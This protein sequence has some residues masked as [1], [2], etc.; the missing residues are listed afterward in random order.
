VRK[1]AACLFGVAAIGAQLT[2]WQMRLQEARS[3]PADAATTLSLLA[4]DE[5]NLTQSGWAG[6]EQLYL[7]LAAVHQSLQGPQQKR[8]ARDERTRQAVEALGRLLAFPDGH[9][10][11]GTFR[12]RPEFDAEVETLL[13]RIRE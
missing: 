7:G 8:T 5:E 4:R 2:A 10:S 1:W 3:T 12:T 9:D 6:A 13:R 11:P